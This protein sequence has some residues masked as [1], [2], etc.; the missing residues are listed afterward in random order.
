M[1]YRFTTEFSPSRI[2][3]I[4]N[5]LLGPRLWIPRIDYPDFDD[6]AQKAHT[7]IKNETKRA[8][9]ALS[10]NELIGVI[11]YQRHKK[12][13]DVLEFKNLTVRPDQRGRYIASFLLRNSEIEGQKDFSAS[14]VLC[15][16]KASNLGIRLFLLRHRYQIAD[17]TDLYHLKAGTD[18][19]YQKK[20]PL[21]KGGLPCI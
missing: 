15:D 11:I 17:Q 3:E 7:E 21:V 12:L 9:I 20:L 14:S 19:I 13:T 10:Y 8:M 6:W 1:N 4:I 16:A 2:D 18:I 5:Y